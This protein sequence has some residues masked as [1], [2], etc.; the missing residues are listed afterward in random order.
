MNGWA[1][2]GLVVGI[3]VVVTG[4]LVGATFLAVALFGP[5]WGAVA[6]FSLAAVGLFLAVGLAAR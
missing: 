2:A 3:S 4:L 1:F 5:L 6:I